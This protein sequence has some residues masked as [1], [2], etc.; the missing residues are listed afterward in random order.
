M[1][2]IAGLGNIGEKYAANRHNIGFMAVD[3]IASAYRF[4]PWK[5]RF[6]AL[7]CEGQIG[8]EKCLLLKPATYMNESGRALGEAMRFYKLSIADIIVVHDELDLEPGKVRVKSGGGN[9]G[10]NGL[11]SISAHI[12]NEY[13]R[14]RLGIGHPG[15]KALVAHYVLQDFS[16][17]DKAW[18]TGLLQAVARG[19][20][21]LVEGNDAAFLS[22]AARVVPA[23]EK[24]KYSA[25]YAGVENGQAAP[26]RTAGITAPDKAAPAAAASASISKSQ[27]QGQ[28]QQPSWKSWLQSRIRGTAS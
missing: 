27:A 17:G 4:G 18:L 12:G 22:D 1:K 15:D 24:A 2:L 8:T 9:A 5:K 28:P 6:Q 23:A 26:A 20:Q 13:K 7:A 19:A 16:R 3:E 10:H 25:V 11:K 14:V 21:R